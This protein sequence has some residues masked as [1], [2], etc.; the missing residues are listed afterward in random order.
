MEGVETSITSSLLSTFDPT[1]TIVELLYGAKHLIGRLIRYLLSKSN[2]GREMV[3]G[4]DY[5]DMAVTNLEQPMDTRDNDEV[6]VL[7][8]YHNNRV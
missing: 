3:S 4:E 8:G 2:D 6:L 5:Q 1:P 7:T